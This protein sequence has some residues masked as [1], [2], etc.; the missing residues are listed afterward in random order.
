MLQLSFGAY[1]RAAY[2]K[3]SLKLPLLLPSRY[4]D[5][6]PAR[7]FCNFSFRTFLH[8]A[9]KMTTHAP[10]AISVQPMIGGTDSRERAWFA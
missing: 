8:H 3:R 9:A 7:I 10:P 6:P 4:A 2:N 5:P 1:C